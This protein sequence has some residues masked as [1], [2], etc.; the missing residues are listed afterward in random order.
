MKEHDKKTRSTCEARAPADMCRLSGSVAQTQDDPHR[1]HPAGGSASRPDQQNG[2][3]GR[4]P[5]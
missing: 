4:V 2:W 1:A 5:A 3:Q